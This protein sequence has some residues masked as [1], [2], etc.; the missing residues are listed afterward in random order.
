[1]TNPIEPSDV[2]PAVGG[3]LAVSDADRRHVITLLNSA[4]AEGRL[5]AVERDD[6]IA[7]AQAAEIFDDLVPLTRDLVSPTGP[8]ARPLV[9]YDTANASDAADQ[10]VAIFSGASRKH[11]WRVRRNTSIMAVFGGVELDLTQAT[12]EAHELTFNVFCL[13]GGVEVTVPPGTDVDSQ[14]IAI[15]GGTEVGRLTPPDPSLPKIRLKGF[16]GFGGVEIRN[17]K[18]RRNRN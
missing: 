14:V 8:A 7:E 12:Y 10:I 18:A 4:Q 1:M 15:F 5:T 17:P 16:C 2:G 9:N 6:R 3:H 11:A 13:F